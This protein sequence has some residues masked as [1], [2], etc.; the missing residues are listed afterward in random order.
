MKTY[1]MIEWC[2]AGTWV[3]AGDH[4]PEMPGTADVPDEVYDIA[5]RLLAEYQESTPESVPMARREI[6]VDGDR[7]RVTV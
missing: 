5:D 6:E 2:D 4:S 3:W 7:Y 1:A